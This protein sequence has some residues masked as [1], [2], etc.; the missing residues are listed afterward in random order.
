[1]KTS[2]IAILDELTGRIPE[3]LPCKASLLNA[4]ETME[5]CFAAGGKLMAC[6]NGGSCADAEHIVGEL[7]KGYKLPRRLPADRF[8]GLNAEDGSPL[9]AGLQG[10][11]PALSLC[12]HTALTSAYSNDV[13]PSMVYAQQVHG[14]GRPGDVLLG[15][16]TSGNSA[17]VLNAVKVARAMGIVTVGLTGGDG[18]KLAALADIAIVAPARETYRVQEYHLPVYHALCAMLEEEFFGE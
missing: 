8:A 17:N 1:M 7:M 11:L 12:C 4:Y 16:T 9:A 6:G 10:A 13:S 18:G 2:T 3:L 15:I 5:R 14:L